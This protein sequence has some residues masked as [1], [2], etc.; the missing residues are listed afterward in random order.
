MS[1]TAAASSLRRLGNLMEA[2][3]SGRLFGA[4][5]TLS[6]LSS[7]AAKSLSDGDLAL[8]SGED[9]RAAMK[10]TR[11]IVHMDDLAIAS[12]GNAA[13]AEPPAFLRKSR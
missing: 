8:Q 10:L 1:G 4:I 7:K 3:P 11:A 6:D 2:A 12:S 5:A 9:H 13:S